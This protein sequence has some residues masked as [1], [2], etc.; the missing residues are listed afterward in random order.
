M[1]NTRSLWLTRELQLG[2]LEEKRNKLQYTQ[3]ILLNTGYLRGTVLGKE[4][5]NHT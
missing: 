3:S 1:W 2:I 5:K 4:L